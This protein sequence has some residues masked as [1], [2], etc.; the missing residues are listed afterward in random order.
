MEKE[1]KGGVREGGGGGGG[2]CHKQKVSGY[3]SSHE[4]MRG[5]N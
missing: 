3:T 4:D 2:P 1:E 5:K